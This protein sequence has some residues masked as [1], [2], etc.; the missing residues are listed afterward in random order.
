MAGLEYRFPPVNYCDD[1]R[2]SLNVGF[3]PMI[4]SLLLSE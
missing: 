2:R 1:E 4:P 3:A